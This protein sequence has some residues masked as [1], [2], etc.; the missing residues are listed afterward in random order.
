LE[1]LVKPVWIALAVAACAVTAMWPALSG[2]VLTNMDDD[3]YLAT[4]EQ[5]GGLTPAGLRWA[6]TETRPY[7]HPL[8]RLTYLA[9]YNLCGTRPIAHHAVNVALHALNSMLVVALAWTLFRNA[10]LAGIAGL[11]FAVHPLQAESVAWM[12]GRTQLIC[13][14]LM[15]G[16]ALAYAR[17][18]GT[19]GWPGA[20][21]LLAWLAKPIVVTLPV[22]LLVLDWF[23]LRRHETLGW[24]R[25]V[26]EKLWMFAVGAVLTV[27]TY[28]S[29]AHETLIPGAGVLS[30]GERLLVAERAAVFYLWKLVWPAWL[31]PFYPLAGRIALD[32]PDFL[33]SALVLTGLCIIAGRSRRV[34]PGFTAAWLAYLAFLSPVSGLAQFGTQSVANRHAYVAIAPLLLA[35]AG[36]AV[37]LYERA[38]AA[39]RAGAVVVGITIAVSLTAKTRA[40]AAMWHDDETLWRNVLR[41]YPDFAY[42]NW[43]VAV[44]EA[45]RQNFVAA[46][47]CAER[48]FAEYADNPEVRGLTGL[49][50]LRTSH[51][52]DAVRV[53]TP[54]VQTNL[55]LPAARY[56]LAC[57]YAQLGSNDVAAV[58]LRELIEREP[59][60]AEYARRDRDLARVLGEPPP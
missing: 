37:W 2:G 5:T 60:Y 29:A 54:L 52:E 48:A 43:K 22:V 27:L 47:P 38:P 17:K 49:V 14:A 23:P 8:P 56:N 36:G 24:R 30:W 34:C 26:R 3:V 53:L 10:T 13:G 7:Y 6:L 1:I 57:A 18:P 59:R 42:A 50:Y 41:W 33:V 11:L 46:L 9:T 40:D 20:L 12:S 51:N 19:M 55:W 4:A 39:V 32:E 21:F 44:A 16:C 31:S 58:V 15:I 35:T 28:F 45:T 25:L